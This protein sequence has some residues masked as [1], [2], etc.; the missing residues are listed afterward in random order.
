MDAFVRHF[1]DALLPKIGTARRT[2]LFSN[3]LLF[4]L[5]ILKGEVNP[6]D[7][8]LIEGIRII[9]PHLY[10]EIREN[11]EIFLHGNG[12]ASRGTHP[13]SSNRVDSLI[14]IATPE[15]TSEER[16]QLKL[17][18]LEPLF[19]RISNAIYSGEWDEIWA[20][21]QRIASIQYFKRYFTYSVPVGDVPDAQVEALCEV[22]PT[23]SDIEKRALLEGFA[24][25]QALPRVILRLRQREGSLT[26][27]QASA[28]ITTFAPNGDI[29]PR[30]RGAMVL[31]D[32]RAR[33]AMLIAS[34]LRQVP[35]GEFR[36][37]EAERAIQI[38]QPIGFAVECVSWIRHYENKPP[39]KRV[40]S[41]KGDQALAAILTAR[42]EQADAVSPLYIAHP[43]D[44][45]SL[46]WSWANGTSE[47]HVQR[48]LMTLFDEAPE[49]LDDFL[50]C[51]V[52]EAWGIESGLPRP[53]D[54]ER[55]Q[56]GA[57]SHFI[58]A[59]YVARNLRRR[60][61]AE[62]DTPQSHPPDAMA[63]SR[64]IAHQFMVV[65]QYVLDELQTATEAKAKNGPSDKAD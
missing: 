28:L 42:I 48:R 6:V 12:D 51:F 26:P 21:E 63:Q 33:A 27:S 38:A 10:G 11:P 65:H 46:F 58:P 29:L 15:L 34:L 1:D 16:Q 55:R 43:K 9:Y 31:A 24:S 22:A 54:F 57:V 37:A 47:A 18:L 53:A 45:S 52:G 50:G 25:R 40:L 61:G 3:T 41:D 14:E 17:R 4:A 13:G 8:M 7:L 49:Q 39:E 23:A 32:T 62:L 59:D 35:V 5:P 30:E 19:P 64:R 60:Y 44:A 20:S 56:Y 2:K 36:Q